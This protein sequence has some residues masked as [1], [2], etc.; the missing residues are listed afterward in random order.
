[1]TIEPL[2]TIAEV[3]DILRRPKAT[4]YEDVEHGADYIQPALV[5]QGRHL[6]FKPEVVR[7]LRDNGFDP[8]A[9]GSVV[10]GKSSAPADT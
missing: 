8:T 6:R 1:M 2:L 10:R 7:R 4:L 5:R 3:A 9:R